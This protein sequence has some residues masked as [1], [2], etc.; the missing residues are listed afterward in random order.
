MKYHFIPVRMAIMK[1]TNGNKH[2]GNP[3]TL[4]YKYSLAHTWW[5]TIYRFLRRLQI[6]LPYDLTT[7]HVS[8]GNEIWTPR[9]HLQLH[10]HCSITA[11]MQNH[12]KCPSVGRW[13]K[14]ACYIHTQWNTSKPLQ[15][16]KSYHL[17]QY[18]WT[19]R[20]W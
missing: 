15:R 19:Q 6:E 5:K 20:T 2:K 14:K 3:R 11:S 7:V 9:R 16:R 12:P 10:V 17:W 4:E 13:G 8:K 18:G 1:N